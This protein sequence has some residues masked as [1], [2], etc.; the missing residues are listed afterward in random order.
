MN[1][2]S[3][4]LSLKIFNLKVSQAVKLLDKPLVLFNLDGT[5][6]NYKMFTQIADHAAPAVLILFP[7]KKIHVIVSSLETS[8]LK[9]F[10]KNLKVHSYNSN[11]N[12]FELLNDIISVKNKKDIYVETSENYHS[13]DILTHGFYNKLKKQFNLFSAEAVLWELRTIKTEEEI[14]L[15]KKAIYFTMKIFENLNPSIHEGISEDEIMRKINHMLI[16]YKLELSFKPLI[17]SG[18]RAAS[19]HP[20]RCTGRKL[21]KNDL[22]ILD[23]GV[24]YYCYTS[25]IT[26][27]YKIGGDIKKEKFFAVNNEMENILLS[28]KLSDITPSELALKMDDVAKKNNVFNLQKHGYGHGIGVDVHDVYPSISSIQK[29]TNTAKQRKFS[30]NMVFAFE[31]GFYTPS[32][33]FRIE[34]NYAVKNGYAVKLGSLLE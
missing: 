25:D 27:T 29:K 14:L 12:F 6:K 13:L 1:T 10:N 20:V 24:Y 28:V 23:L 15:L 34:N 11:K 19:P 16:D 4:N 26:R 2:L 30:N 9:N 31:P 5:N 3:P 32:K 17:A 21:K 7:D 18:R 8:M 33:S 22:L